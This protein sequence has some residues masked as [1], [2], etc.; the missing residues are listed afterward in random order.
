MTDETLLK[1]ISCKKVFGNNLSSK[2]IISD[3]K[4]SHPTSN[5]GLISIYRKYDLTFERLEIPAHPKGLKC[6]SPRRSY[7]TIIRA[8]RI[9]HI[10][11]NFL[12]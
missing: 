3:K 9:I 6:R 10:I 1:P 4:L 2:E 11:G 5:F 7:F 12:H 8:T